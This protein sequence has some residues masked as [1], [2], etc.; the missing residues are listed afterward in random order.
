[1]KPNT[2]MK[3][4][5]L[6]GQRDELESLEQERILENMVQFLIFEATDGHYGIN[7]LQTHE[8]LKPVAVTRLPNVEDDVLGVINLRGSI[9]PVIDINKKF[10]YNYTRL[11]PHSRIIVCTIDGKMTG[12]LVNRVMEVARIPEESIEGPEVHELSEQHVSGVGRSGERIFLILNPNI[13][14]REDQEF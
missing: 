14:V 11:T 12:I 4:L 2:K 13:I 1:M 7:I 5:E 9:I 6:I 10:G 8:V 3:N